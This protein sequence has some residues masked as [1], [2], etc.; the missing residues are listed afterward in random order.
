M[1]DS[2][3]SSDD[4]IKAPF[5]SGSEELI[6]AEKR[7]SLI[8]IE[9]KYRKR[10]ED[11]RVFQSDVPTGHEA[12]ADSVLP[13][14]QRDKKRR[15]FWA[16]IHSYMD[17]SIGV[18]HSCT[19]SKADFATGFARMKGEQT[20]FPTAF[21]YDLMHINACADRLSNEIQ[22]YGEG[23]ERYEEDVEMN[24]SETTPLTESRKELTKVKV[25]KTNPAIKHQFQ[26]MQAQGIPLHKIRHFAC[27]SYWHKS[28]PQLYRRDLTNFGCRIDWRR[29]FVTTATNPYYESFVRW[30][31]N[32]LR[33]LGKISFGKA[34]TIYSPKDGK[35][36]MDYDRSEGE[37]VG[38]LEYT[39]LEL[40]VLQ[41]APQAR[42]AI[43]GK[44][45]GGAAL[46]FIAATTRPETMYGQTCCFVGP[47][48]R[49]GIFKVS[50]KKYYITTDRAARNM[51]YQGI[52]SDHGKI[53][54]VAEVSGSD[55]VGTLVKAP[56]SYHEQGIRILPMDSVLPHKGTGIVTS[57]P[58][59]SPIDFIMGLELA[60][61]PDHFKIKRE[62]AELEMISSITTPSYGDKA[63][64]FL[65]KKL[66]IR[67]SSDVKQL[68][69]AKE[70]A[71]N[72]GFNH[73]IMNYGQF[74]GEKV[75]VARPKIRQQLIES[76]EGFAYAE[77]ENPVVSRSGDECCVA[78]IDEWYIDY[79]EGCWKET[80]LK[81]IEKAEGK[82]LNF[83]SENAKNE[84][85]GAAKRLHRWTCASICGSG[86]K[87]SWDPGFRVDS[88][89]ENAIHTA[90][91]AVAHILH[92]DIYGQAPGKFGIKPEQMTDEVWDYV[93]APREL[94]DRAVSSGISIRGLEVMRKEFE[95]WY[96]LTLQ[97][98]SKDT[99]SPH[100]LLSIY[101]HIAIFEPQY[102][103]EGFHIHDS[104]AS[105]KEKAS[106]LTGSSFNLNNILNTYG[107]DATRITLAETEDTAVDFQFDENLAKTNVPRLFDLREWCKNH[108]SNSRKL[109]SGMLNTFDILFENEMHKIVLECHQNHEE[110]RYKLAL[111]SAF[112]D[113]TAARDF[114]KEACIATGIEMHHGTILKYVELQALLLAAITP[115]LS[116]YIWLE[117]LQKTSTIQNA[118]FPVVP[119]PDASLT[120]QQEYIHRICSEVSSAAAS[121]KRKRAKDKRARFLPTKLKAT[122]FIA[123]EFQEWQE[124]YIRLVKSHLDVSTMNI[125]YKG[126][127][128]KVPKGKA[129][130]NEMSFVKGLRERLVNGEDPDT[131]FQGKLSFPELTTLEMIVPV[132][133]RIA[134]LSEVDVIHVTE[135]LRASS[136]VALAA[137]PGTPT[138]VVESIET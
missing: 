51:A 57:V 131:V 93:F 55:C 25:R 68:S 48:I 84:L 6:W 115:H 16:V 40:K 82:G 112:G 43:Y 5:A 104:L 14:K 75:E 9:K 32:R 136:Q 132:I 109:R 76:G 122:I 53:D 105:E 129:L 20:L 77:P 11:D 36:C 67:S 88:S 73:G 27:A 63:A 38:Y 101:T 130:N 15:F 126:M 110:C 56:L 49:Y 69:I 8:K 19:L 97:V 44:I 91:S 137:T 26:I 103:P 24:G 135:E 61:S 127:M 28:L 81:Y 54:K 121:L 119:N 29:F 3:I 98:S 66:K 4:A 65:V 124:R 42:K 13:D 78:L 99:I 58:S 108:A 34:Y 96:P 7:D 1:I 107:A 41:L 100:L 133:K 17:T 113:F 116:E 22:L 33:E 90:Y 117:V 87:L 50:D 106:K 95:Y 39:A 59:D 123:D 21:H 60:K 89:I 102:W 86:P 120:A 128:G 92:E 138:F 10:W 83:S 64:E 35:P 72:E 62:W 45:P 47:Q 46:C 118:L 71:N 18:D 37:G 2:Y 31:M 94:D 12:P 30:Q 134:G 114:Y 125:D 74:K 111:K 52:F 85:I 23:F 80:V 70:L 79:E